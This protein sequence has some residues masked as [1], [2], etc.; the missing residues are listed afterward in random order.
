MKY[1]DQKTI[2]YVSVLVL[3]V[4]GMLFGTLYDLEI[5]KVFLFSS[6][7]LGNF[8]LNGNLF[9]KIVSVLGYWVL[10]VLGSFCA[11]VLARIL[12]LGRSE[13]IKNGKTDKVSLPV[14]IGMFLITLVFIAYSSVATVS[15]FV[16]KFDFWHY[17][18]CFIMAAVISGLIVYVIFATPV[19]KF[20]SVAY[21][22]ITTL[23]TI[24][25]LYI[26]CI[27]LSLIFGRMTPETLSHSG[28][29]DISYRAWYQ[30]SPSIKNRSFPSIH[31][32]QS[33]FM[34]SLPVFM[35]KYK[36]NTRKY[37]I[38]NIAVLSWVVL[39]IFA[40]LCTGGNF[41][42]DISLGFGIG[43]TFSELNKRLYL[44]L[45]EAKRKL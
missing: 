14:T 43:F 10:P 44:K 37:F 30:L 1:R 29:I 36:I 26:V 17:F 9:F 28:S 33:V 12:L 5:A 27:V 6:D 19:I 22:T 39:L 41:L 21:A 40:K 20:K 15:S 8:T 2:I 16:D 18:I 4:A 13:N 45:S 42:S 34:F 23:M 38:F 25:G 7:S 31:I 11:V 24:I 3:V 32:A 35:T